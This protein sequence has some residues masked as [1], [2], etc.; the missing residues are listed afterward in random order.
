MFAPRRSAGIR[1][2]VNW[3]RRKRQP[4]RR[5]RVRASSV[6]PVPGAPSS[7]M[8]PPATSEVMAR[9]LTFSWP[10]MTRS[11]WLRS[12]AKRD[13][14]SLMVCMQASWLQRAECVVDRGEHPLK[15]GAGELLIGTGYRHAAGELAHAFVQ[16]IAAQPRM[17]GDAARE[18]LVVQRDRL[19]VAHRAVVQR[20]DGG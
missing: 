14:M 12:A 1:S 17:R 2:G 5:V 15:D 11:S 10:R 9:L 13:A 16:R 8:C 18:R 6:L 19:G 7:S 3:M 4:M 20:A